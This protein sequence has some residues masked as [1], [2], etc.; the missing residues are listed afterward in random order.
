MD[1]TAFTPQL[2]LGRLAVVHYVTNSDMILDI[3]RTRAMI[4]VS[5]S[6]TIEL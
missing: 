6:N 3:V 5:F 2:R 1:T 4:N